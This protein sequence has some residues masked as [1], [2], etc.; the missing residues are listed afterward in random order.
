MG[1][2]IF[3]KTAKIRKEDI[4]P[5]L[6]KF[7]EQLGSVFPNAKKH[8]GNIAALG[9]VGK[10]D[11]SGDIDLAI[12]GDA[13]KNVEDWGLD[14]EELKVLFTKFKKRSRTATDKQII[15]RAILDAIADKIDSSNVDID[16][17]KKGTSSGALFMAFPQYDSEGNELEAGVQIDLN[18]GDLKWLKFAYHSA[19]YKGNVK[20]LHRTQLMLA[21][22]SNKGYTFSH[23][24]GVKNKETQEIVANSPTEAIDLLN[25]VYNINLTSEIL[26]DYFKL[27]AALRQELPTSTL[28]GILDNYI[29]IL[30]RTRADIPEDIQAY[31]IENQERLGLKGKFLPE[32]SKLTSYKIQ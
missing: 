28:N 30:D 25:N 29:R 12:S 22:F 9:S 26:E 17:E 16:V 7:Y 14:K 18:L 5:T 15:K 6:D 31:W 8:F 11:Y 10:K 32:D 13:V 24:Y 2:N 19:S 23:N 4:P 1:G 27:I 20:G 21:L 3:N